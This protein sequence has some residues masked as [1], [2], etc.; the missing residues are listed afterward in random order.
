MN[1]GGY[2]KIN[3]LIVTYK[4]ADVIG[5]NIESALTQREYGLNNIV[6]CDDCSPDNNW[7]I[8]C[9][10]A[11]K[12]PEIVRAYRNDP[13]LGIYGNSNRV[14]TELRGNADLYLWV[15]GDDCICDGYFKALQEF[16]QKNHIDLN[17]NFGILSD[18]QSIAPDGSI[19][20]NDNNRNIQLRH[21]P[22]SLYLRNLVSWRGSVFSKKVIEQFENVY[23]D[24]GI[25]LAELLFDSQ[26][27][28]NVTKTYYLPVTGTSYYTQFGISTSLGID[29]DWQKEEMVKKWNYLLRNFTLNWRDRKWAGYRI[30]KAK[31]MIKPTLWRFLRACWLFAIGSYYQ[32]YNSLNKI[33]GVLSPFYNRIKRK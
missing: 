26:W 32:N 8:I 21:T 6:I 17:S 2:A 33:R 1:I 31:Y 9:S 14:A 7:D 28:L 22:F 5:R 16:I 13:N 15:E 30:A 27:F 12:Y 10:Y 18:W 11:K 29:T 4:Q 3:V 24:G 25:G 19:I 20:R 23:T